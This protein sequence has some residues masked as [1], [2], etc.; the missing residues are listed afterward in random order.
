LPGPEE[1]ELLEEVSSVALGVMQD[2]VGQE[3]LQQE[4]LAVML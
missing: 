3:W 4:L 2:V 1:A